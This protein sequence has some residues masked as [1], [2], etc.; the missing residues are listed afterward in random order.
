MLALAT[1]LIDDDWFN[2]AFGLSLDDNVAVPDD[3]SDGSA[4]FFSGDSGGVN[5]D[6]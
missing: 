1:R 4:F 3:D 5:G 2:L 6:L